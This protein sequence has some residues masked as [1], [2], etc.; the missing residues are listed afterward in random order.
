MN[1]TPIT[2]ALGLAPR[3]SHPLKAKLQE[4]GLKYADASRFVGCSIGLLSQVLCNYRPASRH[5]AIKLAELDNRLDRIIAE[6][7]AALQKVA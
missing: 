5:V 2:E 1:T 6:Q 7:R 4:A 3:G